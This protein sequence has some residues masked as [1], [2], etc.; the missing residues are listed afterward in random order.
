[1]TFFIFHDLD[2]LIGEKNLVHFTTKRGEVDHIFG[3]YENRNV[4]GI[5]VIKGGDFEK[6]NGYP[7]FWGWGYED[8]MV[9]VSDIVKNKSHILIILRESMA[10]LISGGGDLKII[11]YRRNGYL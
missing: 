7:N 9:A 10:S 1:M 4:G 6:I 2:N 5:W 8:D 11:K 3:S